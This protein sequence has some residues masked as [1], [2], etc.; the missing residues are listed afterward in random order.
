MGSRHP[1]IRPAPNVESAKVVAR[2][3]MSEYKEKGK[4][5][6]LNPNEDL[7]IPVVPKSDESSI[8]FVVLIRAQAIGDREVLDDNNRKVITIDLGIETNK[9]LMNIKELLF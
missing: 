7:P 9:S 5:P 4:L 2:K 3:I 8:S 1:T 6:E